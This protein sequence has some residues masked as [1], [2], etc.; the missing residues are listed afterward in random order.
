MKRKHVATL[1]LVFKHPTSA[2]VKWP[3][4]TTLLAAVGA[5]LEEA[6]GSRVTVRLFGEVRVFHRPHPKP[7][8]DKGAVASLRKWL[9]EHGVKP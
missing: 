9:D 5:T 7:D 8:M 4:V 6:E 1:E 2:N 3:N